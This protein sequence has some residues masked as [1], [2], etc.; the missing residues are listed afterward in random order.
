MMRRP[1]QATGGPGARVSPSRKISASY[2]ISASASIGPT[3]VSVPELNFHRSHLIDAVSG[4]FTLPMTA[5]PPSFTARRGQIA[6]RRY[7]SVEELL[8]G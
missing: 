4:F 1:S 8:L 3:R 2:A 5:C 6:A 7:A